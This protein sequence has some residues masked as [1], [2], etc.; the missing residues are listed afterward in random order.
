M[1]IKSGFVALIG[2]PNAGKST[3][4]NALLD[5]KVAIVSN[6]PQTTRNVIRGIY[7]DEQAQIIFLDT[8]GIHKPKHQLGR[9]MNKESL[10][11]I[12]DV[13]LVYYIVDASVSFGP[14]EQFVLDQIKRSNMPAFLLLNKIDQLTKEKLIETLLQW[15]QRHEFKE[16]IP[17]SAYKKDNLEKLMEVTKTYMKDTLQY[18]PA[19][20]I[21]DYPT[22]FLI[23][24]IIREKVLQT[25][26]QEIPHSVAVMVEKME[27]DAS[28]LWIDAVIFVERDSQKGIVIGK[29]GLLLKEVIQRAT[30][31]LK[32]LLASNVHLDIF[33]RVE[34]D[35]R[36]RKR[37]LVSL[38]YEHKD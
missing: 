7:T 5:T 10:T 9:S 1:S 28:G 22:E 35:W 34:K 30:K 20:Q 6:K 36:N 29:G 31:D 16:I 21:S 33:V 8:P 11:S 32:E 12:T 18:Y 3:L 27:R 14:G 2:R 37:Q 38:G 25:T 24:E 26:E 4:L 23:S 13:D 15:Q 19:D 17:I